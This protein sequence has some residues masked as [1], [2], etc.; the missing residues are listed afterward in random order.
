[1]HHSLNTLLTETSSLNTSPHSHHTLTLTKKEKSL[2][3]K[4]DE[5]MLC[6]KVHKKGRI[7]VMVN[8]QS[9]TSFRKSKATH[10]RSQTKSSNLWSRNETMNTHEHI[11]RN[12][13]YVVE[14]LGFDSVKVMKTLSV[15][16]SAP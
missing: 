11:I 14:E 2:K 8:I 1:M 13:K 4:R 7:K 3:M 12:N 10:A 9:P 15:R 5:G 6:Q 16:G